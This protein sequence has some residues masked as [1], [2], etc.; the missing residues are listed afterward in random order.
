LEI[1]WHEKTDIAAEAKSAAERRIE[2]LGDGHRDLI[3]VVIHV[4]G[5]ERHRKGRA[6]AEI[7][8][9]AKG[10]EFVARQRAEQPEAALEQAV[11]AFEREVRATR[12]RLTGAARALR[13]RSGA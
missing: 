5:S 13:N 12:E 9:P 6:E 3:H 10:R 11:G 1:H 4:E 2:S 8:C 7:R